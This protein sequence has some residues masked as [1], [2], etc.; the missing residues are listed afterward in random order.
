MLKK[1]TFFKSVLEQTFI[2]MLIQTYNVELN[3]TTNPMKA[4][5]KEKAPCSCEAAHCK[6]FQ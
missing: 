5:M 2:I 4:H 6:K 3:Q 1:K